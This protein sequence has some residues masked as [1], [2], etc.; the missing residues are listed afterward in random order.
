MLV[1]RCLYSLLCTTSHAVLMIMLIEA[2]MT[3]MVNFFCRF[4][5]VI[6]FTQHNSGVYD[7]W[8]SS[9]FTSSLD[10]MQVD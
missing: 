3:A 5:P 1:L 4:P 10:Y 8:L 7:L 6:V 2:L 9:I